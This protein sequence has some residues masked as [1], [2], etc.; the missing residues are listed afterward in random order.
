MSMKYFDLSW[1][2][3][4]CIYIWQNLRNIK[5][6]T[7]RGTERENEQ[8][9]VWNCQKT[10]RSHTGRGVRLGSFNQNS[11]FLCEDPIKDEEMNCSSKNLNV[12]CE[13]FLPKFPYSTLQLQDSTV[14]PTKS[15][16][17]IDSSKLISDWLTVS[18]WCFC[19]YHP[20]DTI[21]L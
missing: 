6:M 15:S 5:K 2:L 11:P 21:I 19:K 20:L 1:P 12:I 9:T 16:A 8:R 13:K 4:I 3:M 7:Q 17:Q 10:C 14:G 18:A